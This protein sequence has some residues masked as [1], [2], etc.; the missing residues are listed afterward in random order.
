MSQ[1]EPHKSGQNVWIVRI[2]CRGVTPIP[3]KCNRTVDTGAT[4]N[5][6][7]LVIMLRD[8][9]LL[10]MRCVFNIVLKIRYHFHFRQRADGEHVHGNPHF[11]GWS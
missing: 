1:Y 6:L 7:M 11:H 2:K 9:I 8:K 5:G 3:Y 4:M 10:C